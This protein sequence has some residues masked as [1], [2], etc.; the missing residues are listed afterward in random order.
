[1]RFAFAFLT[2]IA[3]YISPMFFSEMS[4]AYLTEAAI[5][6]GFIVA[7]CDYCRKDCKELA[8]IIAIEFF[9]CLVCA[10]IALRWQPGMIGA[11]ILIAD[12]SNLAFAVELLILLSIGVM[13][14]RRADYSITYNRR[15]DDI[16]RH[17]NMEGVA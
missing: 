2:V 13:I 10:I 9:V 14:G 12:V 6:S 8:L 16:R 5:K 1:M 17:H 11:Q 4:F 3:I 15:R 7:V